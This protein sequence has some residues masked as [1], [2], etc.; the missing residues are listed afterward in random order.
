M[1]LEPADTQK[2][3][4]IRPRF[5][6]ARGIP[7]ASLRARPL[8]LAAPLLWALFDWMTA[9]SPTYSFTGTQETVETLARKTGPV[10]L[11]LYG[12]RA[13]GE[14]MQWPGMVGALGGVVLAFAILSPAADR[15]F[16]RL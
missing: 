4:L 14:V 12:P 3:G 8:A 11:V 5:V 10:D 15:S 13:L 6:G 7:T 2:R 16:C 9:G 1:P